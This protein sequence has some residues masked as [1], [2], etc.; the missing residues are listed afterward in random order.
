[1]SRKAGQRPRLIVEWQVL[2]QHAAYTTSKGTRKTDSGQ[3][4]WLSG[5]RS[6]PLPRLS[7][8]WPIK[9]A[10]TLLLTVKEQPHAPGLEE[11]EVING[12]IHA[13]HEGGLDDL[14][15]PELHASL[16]VCSRSNGQFPAVR[17][18]APLRA[19]S[20]A[21]SLPSFRV[22]NQLIAIQVYPAQCLSTAPFGPVS[23]HL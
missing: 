2:V 7:K 4:T 1:M 23:C 19:S 13:V 8:G 3:C 22:C 17:L 14:V 10:G 9:D 20:I 12:A 15:V 16:R 6:T 11:A 21:A 5:H 18:S